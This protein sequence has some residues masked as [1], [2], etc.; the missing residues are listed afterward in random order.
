MVEATPMLLKLT[1]QYGMIDPAGQA[2]QQQQ[3]VDGMGYAWDHPGDTAKAVTG[4]NHV[5]NGEP[6]R[7]A[8]EAAPDVVL[9]ILSGGAASA[10]KVTRTSHALV[11]AAKLAD[12]AKDVSRLHAKGIVDYSDRWAGEM[13]N[14]GPGSVEHATPSAGGRIVAN[15]GDASRVPAEPGRSVAWWTDGH[16]MHAYGDV[17]KLRDGLALPEDWGARDEVIL[18]DIPPGAEHHR[19]EGPAAE[20]GPDKGWNDPRTGGDHQ[21]LYREFDTRHIVARLPMDE[22]LRIHVPRFGPEDLWAPSVGAGG[23]IVPPHQP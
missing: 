16:Q 7:M 21:I 4:W 10:A 1:P 20:Q 2:R 15:A 17:D 8:G 9:T 6:G 22:F 11:D 12:G 13:E 18:A 5:E 3:L 14:F 19:M 23:V